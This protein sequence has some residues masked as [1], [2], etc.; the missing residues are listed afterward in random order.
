M[1][2][3]TCVNKTKLKQNLCPLKMVQALE[4]NVCILFSMCL[5][6][7]FY[8]STTL[9]IKTVATCSGSGDTLDSG[10]V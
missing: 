8:H 5:K 4:E 10:K 3:C 9:R 2:Y 7:V 6:V 1:F